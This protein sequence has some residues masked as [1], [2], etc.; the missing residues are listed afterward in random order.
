[1]YDLARHYESLYRST[2]PAFRFAG[3]TRAE[4]SRWQRAFRPRLR[5]ALGIDVMADTLACYRPEAK[6]LKRTDVGDHV[7]EDWVLW[8][9][10]TVCLPFYLLRPKGARGKLPLILTPHGHNPPHI[11]AGI[12]RTP[13]EAT[14]IREG[15]RDIAVQA[16][17][18][19]YLAIAPTTRGFGETRAAAERQEDKLSSCRTMLVHGLLVGRTPV[20]ER[21]W[22]MSRLIDWALAAEGV[23]PHRIAL[24]G[25]SGGGT[26]S[27]F[28][29]ACDVRIAVAVPSCY[30]CT[31]AGSIGSIFHCDCNYVPGIQRLG[32]MDDVAGLIAPRPLSI[33]A[34]KNDEI[35]PIRH[36]RMAFRR[37]RRIYAAAGVV[38]SCQLYVGN[39]GHRYYKAGAWPFIRRHFEAATAGR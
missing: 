25:N 33:I 19:G 16:V 15:E 21:V 4:F 3:K 2:Q 17:R 7:R 29:A 11:Y 1:M 10:P 6:R 27:L 12:A 8:T 35:F 13:A 30:F 32:E 39:G 18:E 34:G 38:D 14:S 5:Q 26:V 28:A 20:G 37:L 22:D 24:T 23:D 9:E 36:V 31:F